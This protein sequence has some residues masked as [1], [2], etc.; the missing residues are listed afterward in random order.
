MDSKPGLDPKFF[1][2]LWNISTSFNLSQT[3][4]LDLVVQ[5]A[6]SHTQNNITEEDNYR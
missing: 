2:Q 3:E 4:V 1:E 5:I 6:K